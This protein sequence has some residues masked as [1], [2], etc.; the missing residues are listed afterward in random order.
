M[1]GNYHLTEVVRSLISNR[2]Y[3]VEFQ[4]QRS[5]WRNQKNGLPQGS[6]LSPLLFNLYTND[7]PAGPDARS[8]IYAD[9]VAIA[10]QSRS[11]S[12][13][14]RNLSDALEVL[15]EYYNRNQLRRN[16]AN[17]QTC[18]FHLNNQEAKELQ[19]E[20]NSVKLKH[21]PNPVYLGVTLD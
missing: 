8:F 20:W 15:T 4:E 7:Q 13:I 16:I 19:L 14:E 3:Y 1:T 9:D 10:C 17:T 6:V 21:C 18:L 11:I 5:R 12:H 2:R